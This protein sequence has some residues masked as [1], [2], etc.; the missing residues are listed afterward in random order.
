MIQNIVLSGW[1]F[2]LSV[3]GEFVAEISFIKITEDN[4]YGVWV[5]PLQIGYLISE[6]VLCLL[7]VGAG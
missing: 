3:F 7:F 4:N 1:T 6:H 2:E 5:S